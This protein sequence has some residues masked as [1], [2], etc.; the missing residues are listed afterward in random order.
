MTIYPGAIPTL[1]EIFKVTDFVDWVK[2][3]KWNDLRVELRAALVELGTD[4]AG[5]FATV[6]ARLD[7]MLPHFHNRG[8]PADYDFKI[9]DFTTD[10]DWHTLDLSGIVPAGAKA[11]TCWFGMAATVT[12]AR[13]QIRQNGNS[14]AFNFTGSRTQVANLFFEAGGTILCDTNRVVEYKATNVDF[15]VIFMTIKGWW[16]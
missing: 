10:D 16:M 6:K 14:N 8:D 15:T 1:D 13:F 2:G 5:T 7:D 4:P 3:E 11:I 9:G 12:N